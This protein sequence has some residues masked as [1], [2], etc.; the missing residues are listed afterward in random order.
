MARTER[1][2][3]QI[4]CKS[5][6]Q[7]YFTCKA[8]KN[9]SL[10]ESKLFNV[11]GMPNA[12]IKPLNEI[13]NSTKAMNETPTQRHNLN[14]SMT[15]QENTHSQLLANSPNRSSHYMLYSKSPLMRFTTQRD[16][17]PAFLPPSQAIA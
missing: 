8:T 2:R 1:R 4:G 11:I 6:T 9:A 14:F 16:G 15:R 12:D 3:V 13:M 5:P 10:F 17:H 7:G